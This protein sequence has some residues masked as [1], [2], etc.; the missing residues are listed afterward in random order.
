MPRSFSSI[1]SESRAGRKGY[2]ADMKFQ[3]TVVFQFN[4]PDVGEAG[5]RLNDLLEHAG[6]QELE[7]KSLELSTPSGT[8]VTLPAAHA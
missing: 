3:A 1:L 8:P 6:E 7:T 5:K 2:G 4:A